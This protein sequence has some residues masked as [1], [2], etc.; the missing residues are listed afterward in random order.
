MN[1]H[2]QLDR[3][4]P[5]GA[6]ISRHR[7]IRRPRFQ[8]YGSRLLAG[9]LSVVALPPCEWQNWSCQR[10]NDHGPGYGCGWSDEQRG[11]IWLDPRDPA[12][13]RLLGSRVVFGES[14]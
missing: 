6:A 7:T 1:G 14:D 10:M 13:L 9:D 4:R 11:K 8:N 3:L 5:F 2:R 12:L